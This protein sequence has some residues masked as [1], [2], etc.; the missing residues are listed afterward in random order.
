MPANAEK[1]IGVDMSIDPAERSVHVQ[2]E[3]ALACL[4]QLLAKQLNNSVFSSAHMVLLGGE[5][6]GGKG[7]LAAGDAELH[8]RIRRSCYQN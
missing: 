6:L 4:S 8:H 1:L 2:L 3:S 7:I 5:G